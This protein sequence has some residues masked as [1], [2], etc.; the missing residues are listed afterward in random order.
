MTAI[1]HHR[2]E[3]HLHYRGVDKAEE[4][5][6]VERALKI[7]LDSI[8]PVKKAE[9]L[10]V[11]SANNRVLFRD[12]K[13]PSDLPKRA[14]S[15]RDGYA[16]NADRRVL[17]NSFKIVGGVGIGILP[18]MSLKPGEAVRIATGSYTPSGSNAVVMVEYVKVD[19]NTLRV[20]REIKDNENILQP[21]EDFGRGQIILSRGAR[22]RP[23]HVA[24]F[25]MLGIGSVRVFSKPRIAFFSTGDELTDVKR[26]PRDSKKI[27]IFDANRPFIASMISEL[28]G[29]PVDLG[30]ARDNFDQIKAKMLAGLDRCDALILSAGSSVGEKDY[31]LRAANSITKVKI[32]V[33]GVAMRP[34]SPTG[35]ASFNGKLFI[36][37]PG[38]PTSAIVAFLVFARPAILKKSGSASTEPSMIKVELAD[39]YNARKGI[40]HF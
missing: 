34:S 14:R 24:L 16:V 11:L 33:H 32:L 29:L 8:T 15:T 30:I 36:L 19:G 21:G 31:V 37:L 40:T 5:I 18:K 26:A 39:E 2:E 28:G 1:P 3:D 23:Q 27:Q 25:S 13:S 38:F 17:K 35:L 12:V 4:H 9:T 10:A 6:S 7:L 22:I 20:D